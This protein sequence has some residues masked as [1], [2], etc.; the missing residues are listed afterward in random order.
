MASVNPL[1]RYKEML[2]NFLNK[3][4]KQFEVVS[5]T[6]GAQLSQLSHFLNYDI[7]IP[8]SYLNR[9]YILM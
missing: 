8:G 3:Q 1:R 9:Y 5:D 7:C 2:V 6:L 4:A